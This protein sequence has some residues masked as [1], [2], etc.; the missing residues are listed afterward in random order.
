MQ[1]KKW[2]FVIIPHSALEK[3]E[4]H[5]QVILMWLFIYADK[6]GK[7]YPSIATLGKKSKLSRSTV[8]R[9][10]KTLEH[11]GVIKKEN[12]FKWNEQQSCLYSLLTELCCNND[13]SS[14][15]RILPPVSDWHDPSI[16]E[17]YRTK[18]NELKVNNE[19]KKTSNNSI[20]KQKPIKSTHDV[21][22]NP[23]ITTIE[24]L[25]ELV[26]E[27]IIKT[28]SITYRVCSLLLTT[29]WIQYSCRFDRDYIRMLPSYFKSK[30]ELYSEK[31][32]TNELLCDLSERAIRWSFENNK[33]ITSL[34]SIIDT[35]I[36]NELN[37]SK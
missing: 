30:I 25:D 31:G 2:P 8:I 14:V 27:W 32:L 37:K 11:K 17:I 4:A 15:I 9:V 3:L 28:S 35:F 29:K 16:L 12:R 21:P 23:S 24:E 26:K 36:K 7:C 6:E 33:T 10:L 34:T 22:C 13:M 1:C 20:K 5:E 18:S 19:Q